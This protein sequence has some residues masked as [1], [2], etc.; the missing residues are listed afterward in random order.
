MAARVDG[1]EVGFESGETVLSARPETFLGP[2]VVPAL[3]RGL[4]LRHEGPVDPVWLRGAR[5]LVEIVRGWWGY[6]GP[7]PLEA[8][9]AAA[10][11]PAP[12]H[13]LVSAGWS[14]GVDSSWTVFRSGRRIDAL[15]FVHGFDMRVAST[16]RAEAA[17]ASLVAVARATGR[18]AIVVRT[19]LRE[20]PVFRG[21][22][23]ERTH[24]GA[25]A[26]I[27]HALAETV[28]THCVSSTWAHFDSR[29][30]GSHWATDELWSSGSLRVAH[31]GTELRRWDKL[32]AVQDE[33]L[34]QRH[35]RVCWQNRRRTGNCGRCEKCC[36]TR[37]TLA[38]TGRLSAF[39]SAFPDAPPLVAAIDELPALEPLFVE[40]VWAV[41]Q[42]W[43]DLPPDVQ[44]AVDR[45]VRRSV[46]GVPT[47]PLRRARRKAGRAWRRLGRHLDPDY[48][49]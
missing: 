9:T 31:V 40:A 47:S 23:W 30:W 22:P 21:A 26:A 28:S 29:P 6:A 13:D 42:A 7:D 35:L 43:G 45:L 44:G 32:W 37:V 5:E 10:P 16:A 39:A 8:V 1:R 19:D 49:A 41:M 27:G 17:R 34:V 38:R 12:T 4:R 48:T 24:G 36:R 46:E 25:L 20:H 14:G 15:V 2:F 18:R 11:S 33:P 3:E